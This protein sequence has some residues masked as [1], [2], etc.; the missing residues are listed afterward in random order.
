MLQEQNTGFSQ[1]I[2]LSKPVCLR[3]A[4]IYAQD[5]NMLDMKNE[6][7]AIKVSIILKLF[8]CWCKYKNDVSL[9]QSVSK[10][11]KRHQCINTETSIHLS[12]HLSENV[13]WSL[14][15]IQ[16]WYFLF[17]HYNIIL[18]IFFLL[19]IVFIALLL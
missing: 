17:A 11:N 5:K 14:S 10:A 19:I 12:V 18:S 8:L 15:K 9:H 13:S 4:K 16:F 3:Q 6:N 1:Y 2:L 7:K